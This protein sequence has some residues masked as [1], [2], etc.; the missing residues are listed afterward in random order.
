M[1]EVIKLNLDYPEENPDSNDDYD[2]D[3]EDDEE[4]DDPEE[5]KPPNVIRT[6]VHPYAYPHRV[7]PRMKYAQPNWN[8]Q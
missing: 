6:D 7:I 4:E 8:V 3:D 5:V 2:D 1:N